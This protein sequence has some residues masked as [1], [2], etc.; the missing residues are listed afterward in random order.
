MFWI[1][2]LIYCFKNMYVGMYEGGDQ[3][4]EG[5]LFFLPKEDSTYVHWL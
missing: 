3:N 5:F 4:L 2:Y 1:L